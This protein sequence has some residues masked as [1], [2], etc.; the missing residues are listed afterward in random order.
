MALLV[1]LLPNKMVLFSHVVCQPFLLHENIRSKSCG[2]CPSPS[3]GPGE[4]EE[5]LKRPV[6]KKAHF[7]SAH[8]YSVPTYSTLTGTVKEKR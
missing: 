8:I 7:L 1:I 4:T 2:L 6:D 5:K 3:L